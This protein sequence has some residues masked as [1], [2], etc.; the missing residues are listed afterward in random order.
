METHR[1]W[2]GADEKGVKKAARSVGA[3]VVGK[4]RV[5]MHMQH[6][7]APGRMPP[8]PGPRQPSDSRRHGGKIQP[9]PRCWRW[10]PLA[11]FHLQGTREQHDAFRRM[12]LYV[13]QPEP[14]EPRPELTP[15]VRRLRPKERRIQRAKAIP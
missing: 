1:Y 7:F 14:P 15:V 12:F 2:L 9:W 4:V 11:L 3:V 8:M 13:Q 10:L 5:S 6:D